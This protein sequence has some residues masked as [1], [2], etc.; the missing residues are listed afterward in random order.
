VYIFNKK[1]NQNI[2]VDKAINIH[3]PFTT[4][5]KIIKKLDEPIETCRYCI[6]G[7]EN[8]VNYPWDISSGKIEEWLGCENPKQNSR[9]IT[10]LPIN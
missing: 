1:F 4:G 8:I 9:V 2:I 10:L 5:S 7:I 3:S 6:G